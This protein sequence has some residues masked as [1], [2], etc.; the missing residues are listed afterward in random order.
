MFYLLERER[1]SQFILF[2]DY[3]LHSTIIQFPISIKRSGESDSIWDY[4][5]NLK[6]RKVHGATLDECVRLFERK[7]SIGA[8]YVCTCCHQTWFSDS[9]VDAK[10]L[11]SSLPLDCQQHL[12]N[13]KSVDDIEWICHTCMDSLKEHK[14]PRLS[15]SNKMGF[16]VKPK[17]LELYPLEERLVSLRIPFMQIREL[18]R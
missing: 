17:E 13:Y 4:E 12:T 1:Y 16:P 14:I 2:C 7:V 10:S 5:F 8:I 11:R 3:D 9:V 15:L 18:P 6:K